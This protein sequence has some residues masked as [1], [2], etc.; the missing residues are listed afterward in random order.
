[1]IRGTAMMDMLMRPDLLAA[2]VLMAGASLTS[3]DADAAGA[4]PAMTRVVQAG[5]I[6]WRQLYNFLPGTAEQAILHGGL[7]QPGQYFVLIR[8]HRG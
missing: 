4:D 3:R 6:S 7:H 1:M 8:W 5:A 2:S